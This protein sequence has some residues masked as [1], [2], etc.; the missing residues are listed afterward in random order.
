MKGTPIKSLKTF[1]EKVMIWDT[2]K[3][4]KNLRTF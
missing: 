2:K 3:E 1:E 4:K